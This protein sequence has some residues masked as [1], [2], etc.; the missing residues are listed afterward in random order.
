MKKTHRYPVGVLGDKVEIHFLH[1]KTAAEANDKWNRRIQRLN[2]N[3]LFFIYSDGGAAA[4]GAGD[5]DF[6]EDYLARYE[7][8][9]FGHK[10][11]FSSK[12]RAGNCTIFLRY[13][14]NQTQVGNSTC[15]RK[16]EKYINL[17]KWLNGEKYLKKS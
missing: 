13:Y 5:Y 2:L 7:K 17:V 14:K 3:N 1:Y 4:A 12:P 10:I 8:L 16:Y 15:N 6:S 11:F 9:P